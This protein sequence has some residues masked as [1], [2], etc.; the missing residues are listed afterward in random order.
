MN[1]I[2]LELARL[3]V[4]KGADFV[5]QLKKLA[6]SGMFKP[7]GNE[8]GIFAADASHRDDL[9]ALLDAARKAVAHGNKAYILPNPTHSPN[10]V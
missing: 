7:V 10:Q 3:H 4:L 2:A 1:D 9:P 6:L 5:C 8:K